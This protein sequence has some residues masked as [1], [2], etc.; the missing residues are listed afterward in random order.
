V[1]PWVTFFI[2]LFVVSGGVYFP[3]C[4]S[5]EMTNAQLFT[6]Y[7]WFYLPALAGIIA[8]TIFNHRPKG[9]R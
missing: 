1:K 9:R 7:W 4:R 8:L 3:F 5:P 2:W 6:N